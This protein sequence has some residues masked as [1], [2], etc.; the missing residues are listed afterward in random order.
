MEQTEVKNYYY[1]VKN[2]FIN[3]YV[4][5]LDIETLKKLREEIIEK[6]SYITHQ[7]HETTNLTYYY[8]EQV[9]NFKYKKLGMISHNDFFSQ[10]E[11][12]YLV[13]YDFYEYSKLV[14]IIDNLLNGNTS[15]IDILI[16]PNFEKLKNNKNTNLDATELKNEINKLI[17]AGE[18]EKIDTLVKE[19]QGELDVKNQLILKLEKVYLSKIK[20]CVKLKLFDQI[21]IETF[22][23]IKEF[24]EAT[25][26]KNNVSSGLK[27]VLK[28]R[29][30]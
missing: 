12:N 17:V 9:K 11:M 15:V 10:E 27:K 2:D 3:K 25:N 6:C 23:N 24:F 28:P 14:E 22:N 26:I 19:K 29:D 16:N 20:E 21:E 1:D 13:E 18:Y 5:L 4:V 30:K 8:K 7:K